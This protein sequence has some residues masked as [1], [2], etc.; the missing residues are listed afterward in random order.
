MKRVLLSLLL[1]FGTQNIQPKQQEAS[2]EVTMN[3]KPGL[4]THYKGKRYQVIGIARHSES[5]EALV[6]YQALYGTYGMW[7]RPAAM[8]TETVIIDG[9]EVARFAYQ[10][11]GATTLPRV[12]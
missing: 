10:G 1:V 11:D 4:Y 8:F 9:K 12:D 7:V 5:L 6:V 3:V 2:S